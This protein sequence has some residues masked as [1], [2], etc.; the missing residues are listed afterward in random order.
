MDTVFETIY[1]KETWPDLNKAAILLAQPD[2]ISCQR[3]SPTYVK[4]K[5]KLFYSINYFPSLLF[6]SVQVYDDFSL[7]NNVIMPTSLYFYFFF[8]LHHII[9]FPFYLNWSC[10]SCLALC[11]CNNV[12]T[13]NKQN[14]FNI[15]ISVHEFFHTSPNTNCLTSTTPIL[16][17]INQ[18]T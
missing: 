1:R 12:Q 16:K 8:F 2:P 15:K 6:V 17:T 10:P 18:L 9:C 14:L 5:V 11:E 3:A 13:N 7:A 4:K